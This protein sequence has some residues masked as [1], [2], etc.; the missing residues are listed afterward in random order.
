MDVTMAA[1]AE[2]V[3]IERSPEGDKIHIL[4]LFDEVGCG[5]S[6]P[7]RV[8]R[9]TVII[10][11]SASPTEFGAQRVVKVEALDP[12]GTI[13]ATAQNAY[14]VPHAPRAGSRSFF[15]AIFPFQPVVFHRLGPYS[16]SVS[17]GEDHKV[18]VPV[19]VS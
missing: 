9:I 11:F 16:F 12:D 18:D 6:V 2:D 19:Y 15:H 7:C 17:V 8:E 4:G 1:A 14:T 5:G 3:R 13:L 10:G